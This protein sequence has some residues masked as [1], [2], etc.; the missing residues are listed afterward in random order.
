[1]K[2]GENIMKKSLL[3]VAVVV[4]IIAVGVIGADF[5]PTVYGASPRP[6]G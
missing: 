5:M 6:G 4:A 2:G 1:L 3:I